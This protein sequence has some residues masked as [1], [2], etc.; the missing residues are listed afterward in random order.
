MEEIKDLSIF[1]NYQEFLIIRVDEKTSKL[2]FEGFSFDSNIFSMS[3]TAQ[4][5]WSNLFNI[6]ETM[7][8]LTISTKDEAVYLL[9]LVDRE[10]FYFTALSHKNTILQTGTIIKKDIKTSTTISE[11]DVIRSD[12]SL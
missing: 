6:P 11:L 10:N 5:N 4:V 1:S 2:I 9:E 7:F 8:P 12:N 3:I